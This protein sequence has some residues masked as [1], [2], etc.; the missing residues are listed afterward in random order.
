MDLWQLDATDLTRLIRVGQASSREAVG[1]CLAR[2]DAVNGKLNAVV[3]RMDEEALAA[4]DAADAARARGDALGPLHGVPVTIKVNTDQKD[5]PTDNGVV[6]FRDLIA[7]DDAPV[8]ANLRRAGAII[9][10]RTNVPA[11]SMRGF[12]ENDLHGRTLN[13]RD[14]EVTPGG[15]SGGAG[16]AVGNRNRPY[17][18]RQR[19]RWFGALP[20]LLL[21]HHRAAGRA[22]PHSL[23][24]PYCENRPR[25]RCTADG[26]ARTAE[27]A[28]CATRGSLWR[29]GRRV[30]GATPPAPR[31]SAILRFGR[32]PFVQGWFA[33]STELT[34]S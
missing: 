3:R 7:P 4:A 19:Y 34:M 26:D 30:T 32:A 8:V 16:A 2:M 20:G 1:A 15:S 23:V 25:Y 24:Q 17:R 13:P 31:R 12:S 21:W 18:A 14:R 10:G 6:A 27:P 29:S 11:F 9:I 28:P 33:R 5:H 22:R